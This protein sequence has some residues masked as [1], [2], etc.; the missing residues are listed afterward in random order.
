MIIRKLIITCSFLL[1]L[2]FLFFPCRSRDPAFYYTLYRLVFQSI[3]TAAEAHCIYILQPID[4]KPRHSK[5]GQ[6]Y[7]VGRLWLSDNY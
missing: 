5:G 1:N 2:L 6:L 4:K 7:A 3:Y